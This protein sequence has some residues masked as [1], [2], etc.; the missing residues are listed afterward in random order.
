MKKFW[1]KT[2]AIVIIISMLL[3]VNTFAHSLEY[4]DVVLNSGDVVEE[5]Q[6]YVG[7]SEENHPNYDPNFKDV[8]KVTF[9]AFGSEPIIVKNSGFSGCIAPCTVNE[10]VFNGTGDIII[11]S[12]AFAVT[13]ITD[14]NLPSNI[15][16]EDGACDVFSESKVKNVT[17]GCS[18]CES[19]FYGCNYLENVTFTADN[20]INEIPKAAFELTVGLKKIE[21]PSSVKKIGDSA[22][23]LSTVSEIKFNEGLETIGNLAFNTW[24]SFEKNT[25]PST[26]KS[27]GEECFNSYK[28]YLIEL[29]DGLERVGKQAFIC[30]F[31]N[32]SV[33][34]PASVTEIG[35]KAFGYSDSGK[36]A[37]NF[38]IY[39][40]RGTAAETYANENGF[41]FIP[42][43][44]TDHNGINV[45]LNSG[46]VVEAGQYSEPDE[47][48]SDYKAV[49]TVTFNATGSE[50]ITV[51][52]LGFSGNSSFSNNVKNI[53]FNGNGEIIL[54][55]LAFSCSCVT[56]LYLPSNVHFADDAEYVFDGAKNLKKAIVA[57]K[58]CPNMFS[59]S[60]ELREVEFSQGNN[61]EELPDEAFYL[62]SSLE[63]IN[64]P[65]TLKRIG[66]SG[67]YYSNLSDINL[68]EGLET[69]DEYAFY[70]AANCNSIEFPSTLKSIGKSAF[71]GCP[72]NAIQLNDG[73]SSVGE[74]AFYGNNFKSVTIPIS[75]TSIGE[76][77][78][79]YISDSKT[80]DGFTIYGYRGTAAETY[81]NENGF[82]FI[83]LDS[84]SSVKGVTYTPSWSSVNDYSFSVDGRPL[85]LQV[86]EATGATR[87]FSRH[88][89]NVAIKAYDEQGNEVHDTSAD[90]AYEVWTVKTRLTPNSSLKIHAKYDNVWEDQTYDF[91]ISTLY[92]DT[93]LKSAELAETSGKQ[94]AV[95]CKIVTGSGVNKVR[96]EYEDGM[97]TTVNSSMAVLDETNMTYT[98]NLSLKPRHIGENNFKVYIKTPTDGWKYA[99][100]LTYT[101]E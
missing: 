3:S 4:I 21:I 76:K 38:T 31:A 7:R 30:N 5:E 55:S 29:N 84:E 41:T 79:G 73:L 43:D 35:E 63:K 72:F 22:F 51:K 93:T 100:T 14:L 89:S 28:P 52:R 91:S 62:C 32:Q 67:F 26:V 42:L 48:A 69:I 66:A 65:S 70:F 18:M 12:N 44:S 81:A 45:V 99:T 80:I 24:G 90:L 87:T 15:K 17:I 96:I 94:S 16:F 10:I 68:N 77:A 85:K 56:T 11:G 58:L 97:T 54:D 50:P 9:N 53:I 19:M 95:G 25:L 34:I 49:G 83:P 92:S 71:L 6:Y 33:K 78:F 98:Y 64:F 39:G 20:D 37:E 47:Y 74:K 60:K 59:E 36:K 1:L 61:L 8:N 13:N 27:I 57:C 88:A 23:D 46:D 75:V 86:I 101:V 2:M 40:Y 82:T